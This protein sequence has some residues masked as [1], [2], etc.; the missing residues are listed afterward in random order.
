MYLSHLVA[1]RSNFVLIWPFNWRFQQFYLFVWVRNNKVKSQTDS[2][3]VFLRPL[4]VIR[5][6]YPALWLAEIKQV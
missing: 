6:K 3:T 1:I 4:Y 5:G 2:F